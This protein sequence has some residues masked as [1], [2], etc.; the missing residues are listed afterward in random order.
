MDWHLIF[1]FI[2]AV[3]A[4][5]G[6]ITP[7]AAGYLNSLLRPLRDDICELKRDMRELSEKVKPMEHIIL[8]VNECITRHQQSCGERTEAKIHAAIRHHEERAHQDLPEFGTKTQTIRRG[9]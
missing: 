6:V 3:V 4:V 8:L 1:S 7:F 9:E 5:V 2:V